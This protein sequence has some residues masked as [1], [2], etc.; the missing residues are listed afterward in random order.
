MN[1][2]IYVYVFLKKLFLETNKLK[3]I[4]GRE[5]PLIFLIIINM[6]VRISLDIPRLITRTLKLTT[7]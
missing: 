4:N 7:I 2:L 3:N 6:S 5:G 1:K